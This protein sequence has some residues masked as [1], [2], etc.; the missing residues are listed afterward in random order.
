MDAKY[1]FV[2]V[3]CFVEALAR[4]MY[5]EEAVVEGF[6]AADHRVESHSL[7]R[8]LYLVETRG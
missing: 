8:I 3:T 5:W 4:G 1:F 2:G 7:L 6:A